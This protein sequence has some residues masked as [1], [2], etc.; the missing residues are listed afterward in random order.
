MRRVA[1]A[2]WNGLRLE[3]REEN[4]TCAVKDFEVRMKGDEENH[5]MAS[6]L[7]EGRRLE[8]LV[9]KVIDTLLQAS[10]L[11]LRVSSPGSG[12]PLRAGR[13]PRGV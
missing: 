7:A 5:A 2:E 13:M 8:P 3:E 1:F 10:L 4:G 12:Y 9:A 11:R 6:L